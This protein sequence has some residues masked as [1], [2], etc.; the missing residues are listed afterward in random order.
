M[1]WTLLVVIGKYQVVQDLKDSNE[2]EKVPRFFCAHMLYPRHV[3]QN[4]FITKTDG[5]EWDITRQK[6]NEKV[7]QANPHLNSHLHLL[8]HG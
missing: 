1:A 7:I 8:F 5:A 3:Y 2:S 6:D 4:I